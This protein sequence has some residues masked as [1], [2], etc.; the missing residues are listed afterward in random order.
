MTLNFFLWNLCTCCT[1]WAQS[2]QKSIKSSITMKKRS[3]RFLLAGSAGVIALAMILT[4]TGSHYSFPEKWNDFIRDLND[5][6][7]AYNDHAPH[8]RVYLQFD[9]PFY[10]PG[11]D[12]WF[13]AYLRE[14][15]T[16]KASK[17]SD[18]LHVELINPKGNVE[19]EIKIL[20]DKGKAVGDFHID[21]EMAGGL[22]KVK[23]WTQWQKN[24]NE[25]P[26]F[27]KEFQVQKVVLPRLKMNLDFDREAFG[28]GDEVAATLKLETNANEPLSQHNF[29]FVVNVDGKKILAE[30]SET[31]ND[32]EAKI[33][34]KLPEELATNDGLMN[35]MIQ[36]NGLTES[37]SR[38]IPIVLN[39]IDLQ[40]FPEGGDLVEALNGRVAFRALN[41]FGKPADISGKIY[42]SANREVADFTSFHMG[43]GAFEFVP[44]KG[45]MYHA[46]ITQPEGIGKIYEVPVALPKGYVLNVED[47][48]KEQIKT[49]IMAADAG[50]VSLVAQVRGKMFWASEVP[51]QPGN[52][53]VRIPAERL[54]AGV[55]QITLFDS[56]G[57]ERA[58]RLAFVNK[59]KNLNVKVKTNKQKYLPREKV[60]MTVEVTD[61]RGYPMPAQLSL[62]VVNDQLLSFADDKSGN[63]LSKMLLEYDIKEEIEEP[64]FYFDP[65]EE[66]AAQALDLLMMTAGWRRFTWAQV[67]SGNMPVLSHQAE[68]AE[69]GG[70]VYDGW[71]GQ[72][73]AAAEISGQGWGLRTDQ[74]GAFNIRGVNLADDKAAT[75]NAKGYNKGNFTF[76]QYGT[77]HVIYLYPDQN[78]TAVRGGRFLEDEEEIFEE[79]VPMMD[80][81]D[82]MADMPMEVAAAPMGGANLKALEINN[83]AST[84]ISTNTG[85]AEREKGKKNRNRDFENARMEVAA[86]DQVDNKN[87]DRSKN[88]AG[89][90]DLKKEVVASKDIAKRE[91]KAKQ[92]VAQNK[93]ILNQVDGDIDFRWDK[94]GIDMENAEAEPEFYRAREFPA[95]VYDKNGQGEAPATEQRSDFRS[96]LFW[97]PD[98]T[99]GRN[100]RAT[101]EFYTSDEISS[102]KT[103][104]EGIG[105]DGSIGRAEEKIFTQLPFSMDAKAPVEVALEDKMAIPVILT[106]N[107]D[108]TLTGA[109]AVKAPKGLQAVSQ[110]PSTISIPAGQTQ[111]LFLEYKAIS[112]SG[113]GDFEIEFSSQGR[114]DAFRKE[115]EIVPKGF[116][117]N[118]AFSGREPGQG[119][120]FN[121]K[122][123]V[124]GSVKAKFTAY[125]SVV[126]DLLSGIESILREPYGCFE[127]TSSSSYPNVLVMNYL[128]TMENPDPSIMKRANDLLDKGYA[129]LTSFETPEKGYEWF[130]SVPAHEGLTAYGLMQFNEMGNHSSKVDQKM[131]D[132]TADWLMSRRDGKGQ[133]DVSSRY[134][135]TWLT[136]KGITSAYVVYALSEAGY[137]G[138]D[139]E[140]NAAIEDAKKSNDP[141]R[142]AL[143]ANALFNFGKTSQA[144]GLMNQLVK[145]QAKDG[146]FTGN[147]FSVVCSKGQSL[148]I[149]TTGLAVQ[150]M[151]KGGTQYHSQIQNGVDFLQ[152]SRNG[153]GGFG[154]T[155]STIL[156]LKALTEYAQYAAKTDE[157]G[158]IEVW[159]NGEKV[160]ETD[161]EK[162]RQEA[163][164]IAGLEQYL[165]EGEQVIEVKFPGVKNPL[166]WSIAVDYHTSLPQTSQGCEV[167]L[168]TKLG[169]RSVKVGETVRL[170]AKLS[171]KTDDGVASPMAVI[172]LPAGLSAQPWQLKEMQEKGVFDYYEIKGSQLVCYYRDLKPGETREINLDLKAEI[173]GNF[174]AP[175]STAYLYYTPEH[176]FWTALP[177]IQVT[178]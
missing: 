32:G 104:I 21:E 33:T 141:Y 49:N 114:K 43:M 38:S 172:G 166:P 29:N 96:T 86:V 146:S 64:A 139:K 24:F 97:Q 82:A 142:L 31:R 10:K 148:Q 71:S 40:F 90:E 7:T 60:E 19:K 109:F 102:F 150:A 67:L 101:V 124:K 164:E 18:I 23:A 28:P 107:T 168:D 123:S 15:Q 81:A 171:N 134:L 113:K 72:P 76:A 78:N 145:T 170:A 62:G 160:A 163:I 68:R 14:G 17:Q 140:L 95:P 57:I 83:V 22:Y 88:Q 45:E 2:V 65:K 69:I 147:K 136:D 5:R 39:N 131:I 58:E 42:D 25:A 108:G 152:K 126:N 174:E 84:T 87:N 167:A 135:H 105:Q 103:T 125:P 127:Q 73:I 112:P 118:I 77:H 56:K 144:N 26:L 44:K 155:Q 132:R 121:V 80:F 16:M 161:Y 46:K 89:M 9:K 34:F 153:H 173:A 55:T 178:N 1:S 143:M 36:Y 41:E 59:H 162:G 98:I 8:E 63:I 176:K 149:E 61:D 158:T 133:F 85:A 110:L 159:V 30:Q 119:Y 169:A 156:A 122:N 93:I 35:V 94:D 12:V 151:I 79:A 70:F 48:D 100:G 66:K 154:N 138:I 129:R 53:V 27:E 3:S 11:E 75:V 50:M 13:S 177:G 157:A 120:E 130:G 52:N 137:K 128:N 6:L 175:A 91:K 74:K 47:I 51:V 54:P 4:L 37:I 165:G 116:P 111:T 106:N 92:D 117:V 115:I 20:A 99:V